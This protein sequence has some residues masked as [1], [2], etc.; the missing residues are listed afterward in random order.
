[1]GATGAGPGRGARGGA[2]GPSGARGRGGAAA[3]APPGAPARRAAAPPRRAR[4]RPPPRPTARRGRGAAGAGAPDRDLAEVLRLASDA[5]LAELSLALDAPSPLSPWLKAAGSRL[6][7]ARSRGRPGA[8]RR[9]ALERALGER[10]VFLAAGGA[11]T[12]TG[13]RPTYRE[14]L[15]GLRRTLRA[16]GQ[17]PRGWGAGGDDSEGLLTSELELDVFCHLVEAFHT[18]AAADAA[19][20]GDGMAASER[21]LRGSMLPLRLGWRSLLPTALA[22]VTALAATPAA[23]GRASSTAGGAALEVLLR[24]AGGGGREL[25]LGTLQGQGT[26]AAGRGALGGAAPALWAVF[27]ADILLKSCGTDHARLARAVFALAQVRLLR[28]G[29]FST[30][31]PK[32]AREFPLPTGP[33]LPQTSRP[34]KG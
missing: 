20:L 15:L 17:P 26:A 25:L 6:G 27:A 14:A 11:D 23:L 3:A 22:G 16:G 5:E 24:E 19:A 32:R 9:E 31:P 12:L 18:E 4:A 8:S 29:G 21:G 28:T 7:G 2:A 10:I 33:R 1:M 13:R 34:P 30:P